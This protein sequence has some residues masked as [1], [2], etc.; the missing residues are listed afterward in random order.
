MLEIPQE[1]CLQPRLHHYADHWVATEDGISSNTDC[2]HD[3]KARLP[4]VECGHQAS[5]YAGA[6]SSSSSA[7]EGLAVLQLIEAVAG[8]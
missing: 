6:G 5:Q 3:I 7:I 1:N 8:A 2:Q 4:V